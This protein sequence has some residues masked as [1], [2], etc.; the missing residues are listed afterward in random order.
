MIAKYVIVE[1]HRRI[2]WYVSRVSINCIG[3]LTYIPTMKKNVTIFF[4]FNNHCRLR[5][6]RNVSKLQ[7]IETM[8]F[9]YRT[10]NRPKCNVGINIGDVEKRNVKNIWF[11]A[12]DNYSRHLNSGLVC[13]VSFSLIAYILQAT[14]TTNE[15]SEKLWFICTKLVLRDKWPFLF[16]GILRWNNYRKKR[17][18]YCFLR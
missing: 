3:M 9:W 18:C 2:I 16:Q 5:R 17:I 13:L 12:R 15:A 10:Y 4:K 6:H 1:T 14:T 11:L 7:S 8:S